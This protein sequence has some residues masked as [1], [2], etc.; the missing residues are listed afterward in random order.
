M[1]KKYP[2]IKFRLI[3]IRLRNWKIKLKH[4]KIRDCRLRKMGTKELE[5]FK[6]K[7]NSSNKN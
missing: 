6:D 3:N 1:D 4:S 7:E 5:H 2:Y